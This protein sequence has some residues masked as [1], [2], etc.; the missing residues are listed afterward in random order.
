MSNVNST[1]KICLWPFVLKLINYSWWQP[2]INKAY[3]GHMI[4]NEHSN[5]NLTGFVL[6]LNTC[7]VGKCFRDRNTLMPRYGLIWWNGA[8]WLVES[9]RDTTSLGGWLEVPSIHKNGVN[10]DWLRQITCSKERCRIGC[11]YKCFKIGDLNFWDRETHQFMICREAIS[12]E[13]ADC[14]RDITWRQW[15]LVIGHPY[16]SSKIA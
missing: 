16:K 5:Y 13:A 12:M 14:W 7:V 10:A 1:C 9:A 15:R 11:P 8:F 6:R 2:P 4:P 3:L